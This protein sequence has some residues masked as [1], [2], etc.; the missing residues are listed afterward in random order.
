MG[1]NIPFLALVDEMSV[2]EISGDEVSV[3]EIS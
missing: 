2:D 1:R 3:D